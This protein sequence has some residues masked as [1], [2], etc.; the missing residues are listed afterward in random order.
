ME[1]SMPVGVRDHIRGKENAPVTLLEYGD[2]ECPFCMRAYP[3]LKEVEGLEGDR[4]KVVFRNFPL[5]EVHSH[6]LKAAYAAEAAGK[7]GK[8]WQMH[9]LLFENQERLE[10]EDLLGYAKILD[11]DLSLF[12]K[13]MTSELTAK[14]VNEDFLSGAESGVNGTPTFYINGIRFDGPSEVDSL[15]EAI[16]R[17]DK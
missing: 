5:S 1:L 10:D 15:R 7:Q 13:A 9:D 3:I 8:F 2:F 4:L 12:E 14:K 16:E 6:A 11:L 17:A